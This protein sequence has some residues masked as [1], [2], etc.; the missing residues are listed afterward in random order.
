MEK[1]I[2]QAIGE[3]NF[4]EICMKFSLDEQE[5]E[6]MV[7]ILEKREDFILRKWQAKEPLD[8]KENKRGLRSIIKEFRKVPED[9]KDNF[10]AALS[11]VGRAFAI[12]YG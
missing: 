4:Q 9:R 6:L 12:R 3:N 7:N 8:T 1:S 5:V 11:E 2:V 10:L